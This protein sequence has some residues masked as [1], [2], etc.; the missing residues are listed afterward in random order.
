MHVIFEFEISKWVDLQEK[1][2]YVITYNFKNDFYYFKC[3]FM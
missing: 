1:L 2:R 3:N